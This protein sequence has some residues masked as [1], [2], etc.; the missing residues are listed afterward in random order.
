VPEAVAVAGLEHGD[1]RLHRIEERAV[2]E[3]RLPWCGT[4]STSLRR[5]SGRSLTSHA[6]WSRSMSP[7]SSAEPPPSPSTR[8]THDIAFGL[9]ARA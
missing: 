7:V 3:V 1:A 4:T 8:S 9:A 2:D 5:R 6:S